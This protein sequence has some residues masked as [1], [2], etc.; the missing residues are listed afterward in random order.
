MSF[1]WELNQ[2]DATASRVKRHHTSAAL[3][4]PEQACAMSA[5]RKPVAGGRFIE[6]YRATSKR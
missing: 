6:T 1:G 5:M 4:D 2:G 3:E